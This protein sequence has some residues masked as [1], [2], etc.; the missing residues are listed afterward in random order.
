MTYPLFF[1]WLRNTIY[2]AIKKVL[3]SLPAR[4]AWG[5]ADWGKNKVI[6]YQ[7]FC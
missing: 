1:T 3:R 7:A 4:I 6:V 5:G 2:M